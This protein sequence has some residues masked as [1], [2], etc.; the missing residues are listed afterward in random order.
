MLKI[1]RRLDPDNPDPC[2]A[3]PEKPKGMHWRS[4]DR[5]VKCYPKPMMNIGGRRSC[6]G[7]SSWDKKRPAATLIVA[8]DFV[9]WSPI[10]VV[11]FMRNTAEHRSRPRSGCCQ[12][13]QLA[14]MLDRLHYPFLVLKRSMPHAWD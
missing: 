7:G 2:N 5:L 10:S 12:E 3:L 8:S 11:V 9:S 14:S 13:W 4:Y 1:V 6:V